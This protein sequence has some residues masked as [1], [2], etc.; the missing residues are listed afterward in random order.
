MLLDDTPLRWTIPALG[1]SAS[2]SAT[3][4]FFV[5][6]VGGIPGTKL[7]N[8]SIS[9][10]DTEGNQVTFPEPTVTVECDVV[11]IPEECPIPVDLTVDGAETCLSQKTGRAG[12]DFDGS[13]GKRPGVCPG[14]ENDH[15]S[16][17]QSP[18]LPGCA[19]P[20]Y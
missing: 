1:V 18:D 3:L 7:V 4:E 6:H 9:Y 12:S 8:E 19:G 5:Q 15:D 11:V 17:P 10:V 13:R 14:D 2:E 16:G 20:L